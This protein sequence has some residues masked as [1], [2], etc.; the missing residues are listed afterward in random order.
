MHHNTNDDGPELG[1]LKTCR[2]HSFAALLGWVAD[3]HSFLATRSSVLRSWCSHLAV[4]DLPAPPSF[5][6]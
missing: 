4:Q 3:I 6:P 5:S 2:S 1:T